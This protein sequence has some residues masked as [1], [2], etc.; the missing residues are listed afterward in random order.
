[1]S[2]E[3]LPRSS[4]PGELALLRGG[5]DVRGGRA[6]RVEHSVTRVR[7]GIRYVCTCSLAGQSV[8]IR[9]DS[10]AIVDSGDRLLV[11]GRVRGGV[12]RSLVAANLDHGVTYERARPRSL[13]ALAVGFVVLGWVAFS[14]ALSNARWAGGAELWWTIFPLALATLLFLGSQGVA[15]YLLYLARAIQR[16]AVLVNDA[17]LPERSGDIH[18]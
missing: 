4:N 15:A 7:Q 16:A 3:P 18:S 8:E 1:M 10:P 17:D 12:L 14:T 9:S 13:V 6:V 2:A 5:I 11:A